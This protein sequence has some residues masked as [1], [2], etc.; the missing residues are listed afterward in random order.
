MFH[1]VPNGGCIYSLMKTKT[2]KEI[3][4]ISKIDTCSCNIGVFMNVK[5][6]TYMIYREQYF[7]IPSLLVDW[8]WRGSINVNWW[9][10]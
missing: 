4:F 7:R 1:S 9:W 5:I 10:R 8:W 6:I 2:W 3:T